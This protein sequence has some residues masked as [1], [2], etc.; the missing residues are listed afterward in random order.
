MGNM[1]YAAVCTRP[2]VSTVLIILGSAQASPMESDLHAVKKVVRYLQGTVDLRMALGGCG[3][4][5]LAYRLRGC[6]L[7]EWQQFAQVT[8]MQLYYTRPSLV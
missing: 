4:Q 5:P 2:D 3:P 6:R 1:P 8:I 7:G